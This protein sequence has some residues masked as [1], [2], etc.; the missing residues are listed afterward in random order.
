MAE[1]NVWHA[2]TTNNGTHTEQI[3][4]LKGLDEVGV[5]DEALVVYLHLMEHLIDFINFITPFLQ[6]FLYSINGCIPLHVLLHLFPDL[7]C[8][9]LPLLCS[10]LLYHRDRTLSCVLRQFWLS[11]TW[12]VQLFCR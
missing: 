6:G 9:Y 1:C 11:L 10:Q 7:C 2:C 4:E 3:R 12:L 5:P 8:L